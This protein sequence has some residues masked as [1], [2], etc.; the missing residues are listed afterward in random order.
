MIFT[1]KSWNTTDNISVLEHVRHKWTFHMKGL[2]HYPPNEPVPSLT[3]WFSKFWTWFSVSRFR[4]AGGHSYS[5]PR[6]KLRPSWE[7]SLY[8]RV[9]QVT[10]ETFEWPEHK[11]PVWVYFVTRLIKN[12][13]S[14][15]HP[16]L[17]MY[18]TILM[19]TCIAVHLLYKVF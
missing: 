16:H 2:W 19:C 6:T 8:S 3:N 5:W 1:S 18:F 12:I 17:N 7:D 15:T 13:L 4:G 11:I 10:C 9:Q 14:K